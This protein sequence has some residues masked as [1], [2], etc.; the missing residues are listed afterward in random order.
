MVRKITMVNTETKKEL[1]LDAAGD[2]FLLDTIDWGVVESK[3]QSYKYINQVGIFVTGTTLETRTVTIVGWVIGGVESELQ[4]RKEALNT[5]VNPMQPIELQTSKYKIVMYPDSSIKYSI[6]PRENNDVMCKFMIAGIC[7]DP[8]F[9]ALTER[10]IEGATTEPKFRFPLIIPLP[11]GIIMGLRQPSLIVAIE[12]TGAVSTGLRIEFT[13]KGTISNPRLINATTQE[14]FKINKEMVPGEKIIINTND[15]SKKVRGIVDGIESNYYRYRDLDSTWL[16]ASIGTNLFR[17]DAD[18]NIDVLEM[19]L[20]L[21]DKF[22]E[23]QE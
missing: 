6:D 8:L 2:N 15:G 19:V 17:Y 22:M 4:S 3:K 20:Y 9:T 16:K 14:F 18:G 23:V 11:N 10:K 12:N 21:G 13:A 5:F 7:A 1:L